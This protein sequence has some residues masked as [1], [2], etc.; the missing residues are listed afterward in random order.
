MSRRRHGFEG[1]EYEDV[2]TN[3]DSVPTFAFSSSSRRR[4]SAAFLRSSVTSFRLQAVCQPGCHNVMCQH[5]TTPPRAVFV[6]QSGRRTWTGVGT[7]RWMSARLSSLSSAWS[8]LIACSF[9]V[10]SIRSSHFL[11]LR[12]SGRRDRLEAQGCSA[13]GQHG[14]W[15]RAHVHG[16]RFLDLPCLAREST[17]GCLR[18]WAWLNRRDL[19]ARGQW[20]CGG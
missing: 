1:C 19:L 12:P 2:A 6:K 5:G 8:F 20:R 11:V 13:Y 18:K 14:R 15:G 3:E 4:S 7:H 16:C 17:G 9:L 10:F